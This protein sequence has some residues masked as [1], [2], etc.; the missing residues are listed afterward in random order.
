MNLTDIAR[1]I[2]EA[3]EKATKRP[4]VNDKSKFVDSERFAHSDG[5]G[6]R[7]E[8]IYRQVDQYTQENICETT[9]NKRENA[10]F[11]AL[12][13]NH[14][15]ELAE[16]Y[17]KAEASQLDLRKENE[18]LKRKSDELAR[19]L[20]ATLAKVNELQ[21]ENTKM[22]ER[23]V[24]WATEHP[25]YQTSKKLEA[26]LNSA[27]ESLR[28]L[29]EVLSQERVSSTLQ[30]ERV[31]ELEREN[32]Q[33]AEKLRQAHAYG[34][35]LKGATTEY[36]L[37]KKVNELKEENARLVSSSTSLREEVT[38]LSSEN[39]RLREALEKTKQ[40]YWR[41][42]YQPQNEAVMSV[43]NFDRFVDAALAERKGEG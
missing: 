40:E 32:A 4:W 9:V 43:A 23:Q 20:L 18:E 1:K 19:E 39:E 38:N 29:R 8:R 14:A 42:S 22:F 36:L 21:D 13:A 30:A 5:I 27:N 10:E 24:E 16:A 11:I 41:M 7:W 6:V 33:L 26:E 37:E 34:P 15:E 2:L 12:T 3:G 17:L 28:A 35:G 25:V 31:K